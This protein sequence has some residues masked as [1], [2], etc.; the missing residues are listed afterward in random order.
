M[1]SK[2]CKVTEPQAKVFYEPIYFVCEAQRVVINS[3]L[4]V[5]GSCI[6]NFGTLLKLT[7]MVLNVF[8][9]FVCVLCVFPE[10]CNLLKHFVRD[11]QSGL[12]LLGEVFSVSG[13]FTDLALLTLDDYTH[14]VDLSLDI[15]CLGHWLFDCL[16]KSVPFLCPDL[17][18]EFRSIAVCID[19]VFVHF[20]H[21]VV[22]VLV[23][24]RK[25]VSER[26]GDQIVETHF[27]KQ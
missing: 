18:N 26:D 25:L 24:L 8:H 23:A 27:T 3:L 2:L 13:Q 1:V 10:L 22:S 6:L 4:H 20:R 21:L 14:V 16:C 9:Q 15:L 17:I 12:N 19:V 7:D 11:L 5:I